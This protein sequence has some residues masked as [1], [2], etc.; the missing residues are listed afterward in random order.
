MNLY[1]GVAKY[2]D[3]E[4]SEYQ[5]EDMDFY[6]EYAQKCKGN[7]LELGCGTG[8]VSLKLASLGY[9]VTALDLSKEMI[10]IVERKKNEQNCNLEIICGNMSEFH[11]NKRFSLILTPGRSFQSLSEQKDIISALSYIY[12][13]LIQG[14]L[15]ILDL[16]Q[17]ETFLKYQCK[18]DKTIFSKTVGNEK[19]TMK[20]ACNH[21][22]KKNKI[23]HTTHTYEI[24]KDNNF[25][26]TQK[27]YMELRYYEYKEIVTLLESVGF[28]IKEKYGWYDKCSLEKGHEIIIVAEK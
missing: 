25:H 12:Q 14:G 26:Q 9:D 15:F 23:V 21:I 2:Y 1:E 24:E 11:L 4:E 19:I 28:K 17:P 3:I 22:D 6:I 13:H 5:Q 16:F 20:Y 10:Q 27:A 7:I 18:D 8:R